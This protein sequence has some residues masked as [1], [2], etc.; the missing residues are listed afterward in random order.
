[1]IKGH[2]SFSSLIAA[3]KNTIENKIRVVNCGNDVA[4]GAVKKVAADRFV[5]NPDKTLNVFGEL[6]KSLTNRKLHNQALTVN[7]TLK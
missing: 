6:N 2:A 4:I 5:Q 3:Y 7:K 1:L